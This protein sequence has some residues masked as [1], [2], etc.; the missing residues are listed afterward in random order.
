MRDIS[1]IE[2][3]ELVQIQE[4]NKDVSSPDALYPLNFIDYL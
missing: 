3:L 1:G 4:L 2:D